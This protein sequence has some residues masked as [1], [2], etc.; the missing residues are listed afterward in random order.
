MAINL[1]NKGRMALPTLHRAAIEND[2]SRR[3]VVTY[4]PYEEFCLF[5][6]PEHRWKEVR[7]GVMALTSNDGRHRWMQ[8]C[9]VGS[10]AQLEPDGQ[11]RLQIPQQLRQ[12][13]GL[14]KRVVL[15]GMGDRFEIWNEAVLSESRRKF[16]EEQKL[17]IAANVMDVSTIS[18]ELK[19]LNI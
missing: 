19:S 2:C 1:D 13:T 3:L 14:D 15:M 11:W 9:L 18:D 10:A 17:R 6:Y 5:M 12:V 8:R 16:M 4:N 7:D